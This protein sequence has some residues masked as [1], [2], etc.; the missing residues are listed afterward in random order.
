MERIRGLGWAG[1]LPKNK[2][3]SSR[4]WATSSTI[5]KEVCSLGCLTIN[6]ILTGLDCEVPH[7]A[8]AAFAEFVS[9][10]TKPALL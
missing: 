1:Q 2:L 10:H 6:G 7:I 4:S 3:L 9:F 5:L 8:C